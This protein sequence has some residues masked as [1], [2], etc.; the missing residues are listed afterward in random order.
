MKFKNILPAICLA[1][2]L[3]LTG[4]SVPSA[5]G[6][7][8]KDADTQI[9][10]STTPGSA[11]IF[12]GEKEVF[13]EDVSGLT[14]AQL[15]DL[16]QVTLGENDIVTV[17]VDSELSNVVLRVV[18]QMI[19]TVTDADGKQQMLVL[20]G[21]T[22]ADALKAA[23]IDLE[24]DFVLSVDADAPLEHGMTIGIT[25]E[26]EEEEA[27]APSSGNRPSY[28]GGSSSGG[29]NSGSGSDN[30]GSDSGSS[31]DSGSDSQPART[32]VSVQVYEDC[33]GSGHGVRVITYSDGTQEEV[34]F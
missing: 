34:L 15:L 31:T 28:G 24:D 23:G 32:V 33:D 13:I 11:T 5:Q 19:V 25:R 26:V 14:V 16:A 22:V 7:T 10:L 2:M 18:R 8:V 29:G 12:A 30:S 3:A 6:D 17:D 21:G 20:S 9:L 27:P 4:C 1:S